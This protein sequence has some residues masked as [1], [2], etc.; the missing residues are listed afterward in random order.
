MFNSANHQGNA[1]QNHNE[2]HLA[3]V[4][5][6]TI[7]KTR[8]TLAVQWLRLPAPAAGGTGSAPGE[9]SKIPQGTTKNLYIVT[10]K[11]SCL[12]QLGPG[13]AK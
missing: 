13:V 2:Y 6:T 3:P 12:P 9:G 1:N 4:R 10:K 7:K 5:M 8:G 11:N